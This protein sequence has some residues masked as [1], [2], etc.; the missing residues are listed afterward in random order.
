MHSEFLCY[1][2]VSIVSFHFLWPGGFIQIA[3]DILQNTLNPA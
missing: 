3:Y 1:F 2:W